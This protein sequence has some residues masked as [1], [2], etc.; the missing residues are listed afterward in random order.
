VALAE[1]VELNGKAPEPDAEGEKSDAERDGA[2]PPVPPGE[3]RLKPAARPAD[4]RLNGCGDGPGG[5]G[6]RFLTLPGHDR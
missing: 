1:P 6:M 3:K 4:A 2:Q 5:R